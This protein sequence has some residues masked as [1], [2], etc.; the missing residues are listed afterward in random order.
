MP[1]DASTAWA[2]A[3]YAALAIGPGLA[4]L[5]ALGDAGGRGTPHRP[6]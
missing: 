4:V 2:V 1:V 6:A 5:A 3:L